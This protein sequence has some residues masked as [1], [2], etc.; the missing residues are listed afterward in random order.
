MK[1]MLIG[2][3]TVLLQCTAPLSA[4]PLH[5]NIVVIVVDDLGISDLG[6]YGLAYG[7]TFHETPNVDRLAAEGMRFTEAYAAAAVCS[8]TRAA[9]MTGKY[10]V[11]TGITDWIP[12]EKQPTDRAVCCPSTARHLALPEVTLAEAFGE[13]G[14]RTAFIGKWH[15]GG[16]GSLPTD[17]GFDTNV[18]G[19]N[20]GQPRGPGRYHYPFGE[21]MV[22][23]AGEPG[24]YL[25]DRLTDEAIAVVRGEA[26]RPFLLYLA[27]YTV[28]TPLDA[29]EEVLEQFL[30]KE[31]SE[32][33]QNA[34]Y[35]AMVKSMDDNVGR[36]FQ[37]LEDEGIADNTLVIFTSDNGGHTV[38]SNYPYREHKGDPYEGGIRV[39]FIVRWPGVTPA[40]SACDVPVISM[41]VYP[42]LLE[43]AAL[44]LRPAQHV[45]GISLAPLLRGETAALPRKA[46]YWHFP[47]FRHNAPAMPGGAVRRGDWKLIERYETGDLELYNLKAD[48]GEQ[49]NLATAMPAKAGT[50]RRMLAT[51]R[52]ETGAIMPQP[53][54]DFSDRE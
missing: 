34:R 51:W 35:A 48:I 16:E 14:Y 10:P 5:L 19:C 9:L 12:G 29:K 11:R 53:T 50:L 3:T 30:G 40:G 20:W 38:T 15:L 18:A 21:E 23:L 27:F 33:W 36:L 45:D 13:A 26:D 32:H 46:L 24:D 6:C 31:P 49:N 54:S 2:L 22:N 4:A 8:P 52:R 17:Q 1:R 42:T 41:D 47:H 7:N 44:P 28:H 37:T 39:P 25:T 43:M